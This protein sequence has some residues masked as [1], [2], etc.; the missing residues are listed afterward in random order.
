MQ[1]LL[2]MNC[3]LIL[4][5]LGACSSANRATLQSTLSPQ[6]VTQ[7]AWSTDGSFY[8]ASFLLMRLRGLLSHSRGLHA[9]SSG[10]R[11]SQM[12]FSKKC[13]TYR[14][15]NFPKKSRFIIPFWQCYFIFNFFFFNVKGI[16]TN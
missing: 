16:S 13:W 6:N 8:P 1:S 5:R 10:T 2:V 3:I 9:F 14:V 15:D 7:F 4:I 12:I 11:L